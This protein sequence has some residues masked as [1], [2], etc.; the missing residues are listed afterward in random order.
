MRCLVLGASGYVGSRLVPQLLQVGHQVRCLGRDPGRLDAAPFRAQVEVLEGDVVSGS[1][2]PAAAGG[3]DVIYYLVHALS[4]RDFPDADRMAAEQ[5][6]QAAQTAAPLATGAFDLVDH[7][8]PVR[9]RHTFGSA[10]AAFG[11]VRDGHTH[12]GQD[13]FADC[14]TPLVAARGGVVKLNQH[15]ANAGNYIVIDGAGTDVDYAYMHMRDPS[16]LQKGV[17]VLTGQPIGNVGD[18]G[19]AEGCHLHFEMWSGPGWYT[20]GAP[21]DPL[22][23]LTAWSAYG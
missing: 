20:G 19:D 3:V 21:L 5:V 1:G 11:A 13:V 9:G 14:G 18:T 12:Q 4:R 23:F 17:R 7:K 8:F 22:P 16:P 15:Q 6:A 2:V 10:A